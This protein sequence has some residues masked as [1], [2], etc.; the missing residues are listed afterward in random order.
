MITASKKL[1]ATPHDNEIQIALADLAG[2]S[3]YASGGAEV[4]DLT[5]LQL[6]AGVGDILHV[7]GTLFTATKN[8]TIQFTKGSTLANGT[9]KLFDGS[10]ELVTAT[11]LVG[12]VGVL[13]VYLGRQVV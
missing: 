8:L 7:E 4:L 13:K 5:P 1:K 9:Y 6:S 3:T 12:G 10:A 11:S 2:S